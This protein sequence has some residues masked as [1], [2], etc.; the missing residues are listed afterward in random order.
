MYFTVD[1]VCISLQQDYQ[2]YV[3]R[4]AKKRE[5]L[6]TSLTDYHQQE[7]QKIQAERE[8]IIRT[9]EERKTSRSNCVATHTICSIKSDVSVQ[10]IM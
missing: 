8:T 3:S 10:C 9:F 1:P 4:K 5:D 6:V 2:T 7:L